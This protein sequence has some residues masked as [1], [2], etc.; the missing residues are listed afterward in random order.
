MGLQ[1]RTQW[2]VRTKAR[3][4]EQPER[5]VKMC[6]IIECTA[7]SSRV[8]GTVPIEGVYGKGRGAAS[9]GLGY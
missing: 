8:W 1:G 4:S 3:W 7:S 5:P 9:E 6:G 2:A